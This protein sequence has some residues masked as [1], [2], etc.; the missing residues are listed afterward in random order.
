M[1]KSYKKKRE[2]PAY[3]FFKMCLFF[4]PHLLSFVLFSCKSKLG[5]SKSLFFLFFSHYAF[6]KVTEDTHSR[7]RVAKPLNGHPA[8]VV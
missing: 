1:I 2:V 4:F 8:A 5:I 3:I 7:R 6:Y